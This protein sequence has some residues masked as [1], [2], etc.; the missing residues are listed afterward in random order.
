MAAID[1]DR[2]RQ[3]VDNLLDNALRVAPPQTSVT[4]RAHNGDQVVVEVLDAGPGFPEAFLPHAFE[5]FRRADAARTREAGGAGL[6]LAIVQTIAEA[7]GGL[8]EAANRPDGGATVRILLL[9][10]KP[11]A[12]ARM[13]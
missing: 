3:A 6:G 9:A 7:H 2:L 11:A 5:R 4:L 10:S 1:A 8:A 12:E 13:R